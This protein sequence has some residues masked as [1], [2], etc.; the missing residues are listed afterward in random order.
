[1][2]RKSKLFSEDRYL[3]IMQKPNIRLEKN[4]IT[5]LTK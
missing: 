1:M 5:I 2:L 4:L 3:D